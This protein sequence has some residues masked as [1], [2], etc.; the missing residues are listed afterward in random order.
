M[1]TPYGLRFLRPGFAITEGLDRA[2]ALGWPHLVVL[3]DDPL[4]TALPAG[5]WRI[6]RAAAIARVAP[7]LATADTS[8][9]APSSALALVRHAV[10]FGVPRGFDDG[11]LF[12][13]EALIGAENLAAAMIGGLEELSRN[14][15]RRAHVS[16]F[17][18]FLPLGFVLERVDDAP[19]ESLRA[20]L[21]AIHAAKADA[22]GPIT[23][24]LDLVLHDRAGAR[25]AGLAWAAR[26]AFL[27]DPATL[28]AVAERWYA[29]GS[30]DEQAFFLATVGAIAGDG[31]VA[32]V[33]EAVRSSRIKA[34][35]AA[36]L[37]ARGLPPEPPPPVP[38]APRA[39]T[40]AICRAELEF[41]CALLAE[42]AAADLRGDEDDHTALS[43]GADPTV[44]D[45]TGAAIRGSAAVFF[46]LA[47]ALAIIATDDGAL[48]AYGAA[49]SDEDLRAALAATDADWLP[50]AT[51]AL[52]TGRLVALS[53]TS[54][55]ADARAAGETLEL[56]LPPGTYDV[57]QARR[58]DDDAL[59]RLWLRCT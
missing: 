36:W 33:R 20:R 3:D 37:A 2:F 1:S 16:A 40:L 43:A 39:A 42:D 30:A 58:D 4:A 27:R 51:L 13:L 55:L 29:I 57:R 7:V 25:S 18:F 17:A 50:V 31:L 59:P 22:G 46:C 10:P 19:A 15:W 9:E 44:F 8:L 11:A 26:R 32:S 23:P 28:A 52:P 45:A 56:A 41:G 12:A 47:D 54:T 21:T 38:G 14:E 5:P 49:C 35:A 48:I 34:A 53:A 6:T 24:A